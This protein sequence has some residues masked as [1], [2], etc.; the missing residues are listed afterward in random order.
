MKTKISNAVIVEIINIFDNNW[1]L[2]DLMALWLQFLKSSNNFQIIK[3]FIIIRLLSIQSF[4]PFI[5]LS[6]SKMI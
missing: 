3:P 2:N 5:G 6:I 4:E 1:Q